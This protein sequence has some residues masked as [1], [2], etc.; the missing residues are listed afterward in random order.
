MGVWHDTEYRKTDRHMWDVC[1][2]AGG[3][4]REPRE[5]LVDEGAM[6][7][8]TMAKERFF[9]SSECQE[10]NVPCA[11]LKMEMKKEFSSNIS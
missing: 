8:F 10:R 4:P 11:N 9:G 3:P 5:V 6:P 1:A 2:H 7:N